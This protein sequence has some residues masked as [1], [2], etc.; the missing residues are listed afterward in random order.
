MEDEARTDERKIEPLL[1]IGGLLLLLLGCFF[2]LR[3][4]L[5]AL[6][7]AIVLSYSLWPLQQ[8]FTRWFRGARTFAAILVTLTMTVVSVGPFVLI[9]FSIADD[10]KALG[11]ATRKWIESAPDAPPAWMHKVPVI[12]DELTG[13]W[14]DFADDRR[15]WI[16]SFDEAVKEKPLR[17]KIASRCA[18]SA[19]GTKA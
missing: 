9:G 1:G 17:P 8:R 16:K 6:M 15:R 10:A 11:T 12:G 19:D 2:V 14:N 18:D 7:W 4:F 5:S 13:Y 3:P